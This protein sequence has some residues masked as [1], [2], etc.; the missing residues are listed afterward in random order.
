MTRITFRNHINVKNRLFTHLSDRLGSDIS[1][2][3]QSFIY[4]YDYAYATSK[5]NH[6]NAIATKFLSSVLKNI[7]RYI[8][9]DIGQRN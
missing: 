6:E 1:V 4:A 2:E 9:N 8:S 3:N 5:D 7:Q